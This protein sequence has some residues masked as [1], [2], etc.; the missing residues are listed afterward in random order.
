MNYILYTFIDRRRSVELCPTPTIISWQSESGTG[1]RVYAQE[2]VPSCGVCYGQRCCSFT[3]D[4]LLFRFY[5][6]F[7][8]CPKL[9]LSTH[10]RL[11]HDNTAETLLSDDRRHN[12]MTDMTWAAD[13]ERIGLKVVC[14]HGSIMSL[15]PCRRSRAPILLLLLVLC[16]M[17][18]QVTSLQH[19]EKCEFSSSS[20]QESHFPQSTPGP[21]QPASMRRQAKQRPDMIQAAIRSTSYVGGGGGPG[22]T[23]FCSVCM[24]AIC[25]R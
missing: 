3:W 17:T 5:S 9:Y 23:Y 16:L 6:A 2:M 1:L 11:L 18:V 15:I 8:G 24:C 21:Y 4:A 13:G 19:R 20:R 10:T 14:Q 7:I 22:S 25:L 12:T